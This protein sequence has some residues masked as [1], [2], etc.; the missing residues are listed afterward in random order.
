M[1]DNHHDFSVK[2]L[3]IILLVLTALEVIW[4]YIGNEYFYEK[5]LPLWGGLLLCAYWKGY[6]IL[7]Y[8]MHIK[9]EGMIVKGNILFTIPLVCYLIGALFSARIRACS[10]SLRLKR[11][12]KRAPIR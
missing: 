8:F 1:S 12:K 5:K 9:Y 10:D 11:A 6:Y 4:G 2:K 3:W 7:M